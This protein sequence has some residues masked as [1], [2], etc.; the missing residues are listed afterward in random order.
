MNCE[1]HPDYDD[2]DC[3]PCRVVE[4]NAIEMEVERWKERNR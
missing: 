4:E 2:N 1:W 3:E